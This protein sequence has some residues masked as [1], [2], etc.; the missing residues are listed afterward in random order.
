MV[1]YNPIC[2]TLSVTSSPWR[3]PLSLAARHRRHGIALMAAL[4]ITV[5]FAVLGLSLLAFMEQ[6]NAFAN[7]LQANAGAYFA[8][9]SGLVYYQSQK[10]KFVAGTSISQALPDPYYTKSFTVTVDLLLTVTSTGSVTTPGGRL[11]STRTLV[12]PKGN[13]AAVEDASQ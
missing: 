7:R 2:Y 4:C 9:R 3:P 6:G 8:A 11:L 5:F 12:V 13:F 1:L 10:A